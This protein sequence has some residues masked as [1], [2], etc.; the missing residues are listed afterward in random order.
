MYKRWEN[1]GF[2]T[3]Y[4]LLPYNL[5]YGIRMGLSA[6]T[7]SGLTLDD[8]SGLANLLAQIYYND[9]N[10]ELQYQSREFINQIKERTHAK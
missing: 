4:R 1:C 10:K 8:I 2:L 5:G 7:V 3:N 6:A 9:Y